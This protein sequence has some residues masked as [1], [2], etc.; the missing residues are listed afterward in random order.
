MKKQFFR[1]T[2][3]RPNVHS[4]E[5]LFKINYK[6]HLKAETRK[7]KGNNI[8]ILVV[9]HSLHYVQD[10]NYDHFGEFYRYIF[11]NVKHR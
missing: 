4:R 2:Y 10:V 6:E 8:T 9:K 3:A 5:S 7:G 11:I 1:L